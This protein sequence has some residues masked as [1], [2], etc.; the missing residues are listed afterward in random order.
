MS[1]VI[2]GYGPGRFAVEWPTGA[3]RTFS[4]DQSG[5]KEKLFTVSTGLVVF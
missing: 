1:I 5:E 4:K 2:V 3:W